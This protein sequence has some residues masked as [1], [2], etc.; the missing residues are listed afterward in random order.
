M[1]LIPVAITIYIAI[2][3]E[4]IVIA[5]C[6]GIVITGATGVLIGAMDLIQVDPAEGAKAALVSVHGEGLD[7]TVDGILYAGIASMLQVVVLALFL[8]GCIQIM[9]EGHGDLKLLN[10]LE[11]VARGTKS[12]E[13][14]ISAM[15]IALS[16]VMGLNAPAI[17]FT[18]TFAADTAVPLRPLD[19]TPFV[20]YAWAMLTVMAVSIVLGIGRY[21][22]PSGETVQRLREAGNYDWP[23]DYEEQMARAAGRDGG[24]AAKNLSS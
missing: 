17:I 1:I 4:D 22:H 13:F 8:F 14:T 10:A 20:M 7:R 6:V 21:D 23:E 16:A 12:T 15:V 11:G 2:R 19:I 5:M 9:R 24:H 18:L 3:T